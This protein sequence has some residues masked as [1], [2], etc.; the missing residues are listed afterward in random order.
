MQATVY[1]QEKLQFKGVSGE[2]QILMD[3]SAGQAGPTPMQVVLMG[4]GACSGMDVVSILE[5][6]R[7]PFDKF[8]IKL[9]AQR[10]SEHPKVFTQVKMVYQI[11]GKDIPAEKLARAI[12]LTQ[13]KYCSVLHMINKSAQILFSSEIN[14]AEE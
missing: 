11:W 1:W 12:E 13:E 9:E 10:Q 7:V 6:M 14:P 8:Q 4:L 3:S 2:H 5:K